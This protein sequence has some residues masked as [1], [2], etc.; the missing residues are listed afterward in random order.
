MSCVTA[1]S[2]SGNKISSP[3]VEGEIHALY[4]H[5]A[6]LNVVCVCPQE[7]CFQFRNEAAI[8]SS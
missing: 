1:H 7:G 2:S 5:S 3:P 4:P 6:L 8:P